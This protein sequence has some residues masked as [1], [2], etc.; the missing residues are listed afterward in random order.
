MSPPHSGV[1][2]SGT[3]PE[4]GSSVCSASGGLHAALFPRSAAA[5]LPNTC[6]LLSFR[7]W[8]FLDYHK[9]FSLIHHFRQALQRKVQSQGLGQA[10][11]SSA[12][13]LL[14]QAPVLP[15]SSRVSKCTSLP[16]R[17]PSSAAWLPAE[18]GCGFGIVALLH[19]AQP[20]LGFGFPQSPFTT[21]G[22]WS[23]HETPVRLLCVS[24]RPVA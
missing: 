23:I 4:L 9:Y 5:V 15:L 6:C 24:P 21:L 2:P 11:V 22:R 20:L 8:E 19:C 14:P 7:C 1:V 12:G 17:P 3:F 16:C 18:A 13:V 10:A